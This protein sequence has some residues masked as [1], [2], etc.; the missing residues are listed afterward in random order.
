MAFCITT[1][2]GSD[3]AKWRAMIGAHQVSFAP[4]YLQYQ[5][6]S[7]NPNPLPF[8]YVLMLVLCN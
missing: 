1:V 6:L 2:D 3:K 4:P 5:T 7:Q 8:T